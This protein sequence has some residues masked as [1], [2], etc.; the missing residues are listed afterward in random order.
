[1]AQTDNEP[2]LDASV[3]PPLSRSEELAWWVF[4]LLACGG[5]A[6]RLVWRQ[7]SFLSLPLY[8]A[9]KEAMPYQG[10][11]LMAWVLRFTAGNAHISSFLMRF[12]RYCPTP[13]RDPYLLVLLIVHFVSIV[14]AI[15]FGRLS[16]RVLTGSEKFSA[17]T[18]LLVLYMSYFNLVIGY[19][20]FMM[21]YDVLSL[22][23]FSLAVWLILSQRYLWL[24]PLVAIEELNRD[25]AFF[26]PIFLFFYTWFAREHISSKQWI[27][28][29]ANI[30]AQLVIC[31]LITVWILHQFRANVLAVD[32]HNHWF[33]IQIRPNFKSLIKPPQWPLFLSLFGFSLPLFIAK[34]QRVGNRRLACSAAAIMLTWLAVSLIVGSIVEIRIFN[35]LTAFLMPCI[36]LILWNEWVMPA[37]KY[38]QLA[39]KEYRIR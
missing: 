24:L 31:S 35:E 11:I 3:Q 33:G 12:A 27:K 39:A 20:V 30:I 8:A 13:I 6:L 36:A 2:P 19:D 25:T 21:P 16:L 37:A 9:G 38:R 18:A 28:T 29:L 32:L 1:M 22:A 34:F 15:C 4:T 10:R 26:I 23:L 7:G 14:A 17:W 5:F